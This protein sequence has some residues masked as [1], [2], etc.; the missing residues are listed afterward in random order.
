[1]SIWLEGNSLTDSDAPLPSCHFFLAS[2]L[3]SFI[4][5]QENFALILPKVYLFEEN[6]EPYSLPHWL[7]TDYPFLYNLQS[8][9]ALSKQEIVNNALFLSTGHRGL[10]E[11]QSLSW[12]KISLGS[13]DAGRLKQYREVQHKI[14]PFLTR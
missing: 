5:H 13:Y 7:S 9:I 11:H 6:T 3:V 1:M 4:W 2:M 12:Q 10:R 8:A 14:R